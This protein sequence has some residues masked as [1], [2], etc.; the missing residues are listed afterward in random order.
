MFI[1]NDRFGVLLLFFIQ[2]LAHAEHGVALAG[3]GGSEAHELGEE[4]FRQ[5]GVVH[6]QRLLDFDLHAF[7]AGSFAHAVAAESQVVFELGF[8]GVKLDRGGDFGVVDF[9]GKRLRVGSGG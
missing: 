2:L 5:S 3:G 4:F 6:F 8:E 1:N 7:H 9:I